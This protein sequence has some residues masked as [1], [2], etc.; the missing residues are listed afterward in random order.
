[1]QNALTNASI[2]IIQYKQYKQNTHKHNTNKIMP[3]NKNKN[4]S[5]LSWLLLCI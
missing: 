1:M 3:K 5:P 2:F 4:F